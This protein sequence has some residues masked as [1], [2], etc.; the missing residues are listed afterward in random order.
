[1]ATLIKAPALGKATKATRAM[2][3]LRRSIPTSRPRPGAV[4]ALTERIPRHMVL[5]LRTP[6]REAPLLCSS[7]ARVRRRTTLRLRLLGSSASAV[8]TTLPVAIPTVLHRPC[9]L[10]RTPILSRRRSRTTRHQHLLAR[11]LLLP[12]LRRLRPR[13]RTM[14][15]RAVGCSGVYVRAFW[16]GGIPMLTTPMTIS[17]RAW[18]LYLTKRPVGGNSLE[19]RTP[20]PVRPLCLPP[21]ARSAVAAA[22]TVA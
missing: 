19:R 4:L 11:P 10:A 22:A 5:I 17:A 12:L 7:I 9:H 8:E 13:R 3:R 21:R 14:V 1:M 16:R 15:L 6:L 18:R 2:H 20:P